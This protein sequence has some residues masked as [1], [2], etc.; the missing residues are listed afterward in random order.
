MAPTPSKGGR[1]KVFILVLK[2]SHWKLDSKNW[3]IQF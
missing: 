1:G 2:N 3:N